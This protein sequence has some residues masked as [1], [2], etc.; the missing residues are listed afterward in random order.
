MVSLYSPNKPYK[1]YDQKAWRSDQRNPLEYG[2][3]FDFSRSLFD[4][5]KELQ[6]KVPRLSIFNLKSTNSGY[7]N[8]SADNK[9][10]Y[11]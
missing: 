4:Q 7:T 1:V 8:H 10:C 3:D 11:M 9:N 5:F 2:Q 6:K